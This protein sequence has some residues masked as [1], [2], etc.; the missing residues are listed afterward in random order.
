MV[1]DAAAA[2]G[3]AVADVVIGLTAWT[4]IDPLASLLIGVIIA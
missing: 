2:L 1:G 4:A 3:V